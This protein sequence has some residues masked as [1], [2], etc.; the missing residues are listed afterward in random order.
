MV[1][2][3]LN[4]F[5]FSA[6]LSLGNSSK[7]AMSGVGWPMTRRTAIIC[8]K[9]PELSKQCVK[10]HCRDAGRPHAQDYSFFGLLR[11]AASPSL[12]ICDNAFHE[13]RIDFCLLKE[14]SGVR[15]TVFLSLEG[16]DTRNEFR[17]NAS[18]VQIF[19]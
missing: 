2:V 14:I 3:L 9:K 4:L 6:I 12:V 15:L 19:C 18:H 11:Q 10:M 8:F 16:E 13:V 1:L 7:S 17:R 5:P